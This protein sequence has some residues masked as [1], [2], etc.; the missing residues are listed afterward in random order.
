MIEHSLIITAIRDTKAH[1]D[2][3]SLF[4]NEEFLTSISREIAVRERLHTGMIVTAP[5]LEYIVDLDQTE[6]AIDHAVRYLAVKARSVQQLTRYLERKDYQDK[7][8]QNT[9]DKLLQL[10]Y[11]DD[12]EFASNFVRSRFAHRPR[13]KKLI[14][15]ELSHLGIQQDLARQALNE[16]GNE[17]EAALRLLM[18]RASLLK[19]PDWN[20]VYRKL[21]A[22]LTRKG[23]SSQTMM[24]VLN[25]AKRQHQRNHN[26]DN[27]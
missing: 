2:R 9:I 6:K 25:E 21:G 18:S 15:A 17:Q 12:L 5:F 16:Y 8:I 7:V 26:L 20:V 11:L 27:D 1:P 14:Q 3:V 22:F 4:V 23:F 19:D 10:G 13:G 24:T